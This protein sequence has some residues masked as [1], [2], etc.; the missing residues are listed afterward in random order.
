MTVIYPLY[1]VYMCD[2]VLNDLNLITRRNYQQLQ[3]Q[4]FTQFHQ[5]SSFFF[6]L[7][8]ETFVNGNEAKA[9]AILSFAGNTKLVCY[10]AAQNGISQL[11][12]FT[13]RQ[14]AHLSIGF[15]Q[16]ICV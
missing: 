14:L 2:K 6:I 5:V 13:A 7:I 9:F 10:G 11:R 1:Q 15:L 3:V 12:L 8:A 16:L 4:L